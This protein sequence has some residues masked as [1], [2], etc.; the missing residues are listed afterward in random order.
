MRVFFSDGGQINGLLAR[1]KGSRSRSGGEHGEAV[2]SVRRGRRSTAA[3]TER[4]R[5]SVMFTHPRCRSLALTS[6]RF[7]SHH[8]AIFSRLIGQTMTHPFARRLATGLAVPA[9]SSHHASHRVRRC[10]SYSSVTLSDSFARRTRGSD[11]PLESVSLPSHPVA[12]LTRAAGPHS[13]SLPDGRTGTGPGG[14]MRAGTR[15]PSSCRVSA[16]RVHLCQER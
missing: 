1:N 8:L 13:D 12:V 9:H 7:A 14:R 3:H 4:C 11:S 10:L 15:R 16:G 2:R 5:R 6:L